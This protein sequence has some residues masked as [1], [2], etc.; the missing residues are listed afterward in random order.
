MNLAVLFGSSSNEHEV[1]VA[2]SSAIIENLD[3]KKYK[4]TPIYLDKTNT[5]Y[6]CL[7]KININRVGEI[8][9]KLEKISNPFEYLQE[10]DLVFLM[11]HGKNG[12]DGILSSIFEFLNIKYVGHSPL[13]SIL[14]MDKILT[15]DILELN[16]IKTSKYLYFTKYNNDYIYKDNSYDL[17]KIL[18]IIESNLKYPMFIKP[19]KSGSSIGVEKATDTN[20][21][22]IA[23]NNALTI[24]NR[25]LIEE[26]IKGRELE[27]GI[28]EKNNE[29]IASV[30]GEVKAAEE[31][32]SFSS[33]YENKESKT[34]IPANI[35]PAEIKS[36][37]EIAIKACKILDIHKYSRCDFFLTDDGDIL[38]NE[39]NTIPGFTEISMYPKLFIETGISYQELLDILINESM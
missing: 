6:K 24:D 36:I 25:I 17:A 35:K 10:F 12:E 23:I 7:E 30:V 22:K 32:Y 14:T 21:L 2:S 16:N 11:I 33:K 27:C 37:Q 39:I 3:Q 38:L 15:K 26:E 28:L 18:D 1:S 9:Q 19:A 34:I 8:P 4:I 5:F 13:T 29:L 31:F 20:S